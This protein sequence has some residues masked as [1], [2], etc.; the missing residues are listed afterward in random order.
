MGAYLFLVSGLAVSHTYL[1][2]VKIT[3]RVLPSFFLP[4]FYLLSFNL[5]DSFPHYEII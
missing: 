5:E 4:R 3:N 2:P 1:V